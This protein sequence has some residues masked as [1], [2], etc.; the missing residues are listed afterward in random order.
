MGPK[1]LVRLSNLVGLVA[2][3]LLIYWVFIFTLTE[4]FDLKIFREN[5][6]ETFYLSVLGI[7]ALMGG[8]LMIN[9]MF[10]LTRMADKHNADKE[11]NSLAFRRIVVL[12][13]LTFPVIAVFLFTGDYM[14]KRKKEQMLIASAE[15]ILT[16][17]K[18]KIDSLAN[19]E[20]SLEWLL[21]AD[22][23]FY[24]LYGLDRNLPHI[25]MIVADN[26]ENT[27]VYLNYGKGAIYNDTILPQKKKYIL[28]TTQLERNYLKSVFEGQ[29]N[30][31]C[32]NKDGGKSELFYPY[33]YKGKKVVFYLSD[34]Y[35][36]GKFGS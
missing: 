3:I 7:L 13:V 26:I 15:S 25:S 18:T 5:M 2:I 28:K 12:F 14:S 24:L 33:T 11:Y 1:Q 30:E 27:D 22:N 9:I 16:D 32:F 17:H 8:A 10:N 23:T 35:N 29:V 4:V 31:I 36:Y 20:Y 34:Y 19:Y 6:T 21:Y